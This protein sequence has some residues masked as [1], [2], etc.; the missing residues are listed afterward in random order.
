M[1]ASML[2]HNPRCSKSRAALALLEAHGIAPQIVAYLEQAPSPG[3]IAVLLRQLGLTDARSLMRQGEAEYKELGL[4]N[5]ALSQ[6]ALIAAL[7]ANPRLIE[8]PVFVH[9]ER[10]IIGRPPEKVLEIL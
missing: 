9:G 10:A 4:A 5:P 2:Y 3:E 6:E 8:R 1:N 7:A